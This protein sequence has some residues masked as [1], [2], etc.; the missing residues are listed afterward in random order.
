MDYANISPDGSQIIYDINNDLY[1]VSSLGGV[2]K[3][4]ADN[5]SVGKWIPMAVKLA[6]FVII[7]P[8]RE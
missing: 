5:I 8:K 3:K 7:I 1:I 4:I 2:E 6:L